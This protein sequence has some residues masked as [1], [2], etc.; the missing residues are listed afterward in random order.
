[1]GCVCVVI[2][3]K[4]FNGDPANDFM[5]GR[6]LQDRDRYEGGFWGGDLKDVISKLDD[7]RDLGVTTFVRG[8]PSKPED[9]LVGGMAKPAGSEAPIDVQA[10]DAKVMRIR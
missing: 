2:I 3:E 6:F 8:V 9:L 7:L 1:M 5:R 10:Y 4:F